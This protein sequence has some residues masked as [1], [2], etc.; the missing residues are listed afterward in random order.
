MTHEQLLG[1]METLTG[2]LHTSTTAEEQA[3]NNVQQ[4]LASSLAEQPLPVSN[5]QFSF[6][7]SDMFFPQNIQSGRLAN[8]EEIVS[9]TLDKK[10]EADLRVFARDLPVHTTQ[11][12]GSVPNWAAG[13]R[14][15]RTEGPFINND[16]RRIWFD[17]YRIERLVAIYIQGQSNPV[18]LF[19]SEF[20]QRLLD[21]FVNKNFRLIKSFKVLPG[22]VWVNAHALAPD[23]P[24]DRFTGVKVTGGSITLD[25]VPTL[26]GNNLTVDPTNKINV[27]LELDQETDAY[28]SVDSPY[29][30]DAR[31][32]TFHLP[33]TWNFTLVGTGK[34]ITT[35][36]E[37]SAT[38]YGQA[39]NFA[40]AGN[41]A[42]TY[43]AALSKVLIPW[44]AD[45]TEFDVSSSES[46]FFN[47]SGKAP[48]GGSW[49]A[50]PA[51][52]IDVSAP[53]EA[54]GNGAVLIACGK[55]L[56]AT[57]AGL[58][59]Q[60]MVFNQPF[61]MGEP[62]RIGLTDLFSNG[63]GAS[64]HLELWKDKKN[65]HGNSVD[66]LFLSSAAF[67][68]NSVTKGD[69][70]LI[71][72]CNAGLNIDRPVKVNG[73]PF[74]VKSKN[75][76]L[77]MAANASLRLLYLYDDNIIWDNTLPGENVPSQKLYS[78]AL[79]N[80]L[81]TV[82]A[83]NGCLL[84][85]TC[86]EGWKKITASNL[87]LTFGMYS[88]LPTLPDPYLV[89]LN[90][91]LQQFRNERYPAT[92]G[93]GKRTP[94]L[95]L[96]CNIQYKPLDETNDVVNVG[97]HFGLMPAQQQSNAQPSTHSGIQNTPGNS[98]VGRNLFSDI[99]I[100]KEKGAH[101]FASQKARET[102]EGIHA[103][104]PM[105]AVNNQLPDY[106]ALWD[107]RFGFLGSDAFALLDVSSNANQ[108]GVSFGGFSRRDQMAF[109][110][111]GNIVSAG[112][113]AAAVDSS[114]FPFIVDGMEVKASG[115]SVRAFM[116]P[117]VAWEP[118]F[119]LSA[120][121]RTDPLVPTSPK[122]PMDPEV[123]FKYFANDGGPTRILNNSDKPVTLAPIPLVDFLMDY[124]KNDPKSILASSLTLPFGLRAL[125]YITKNSQLLI[126]NNPIPA[127]QT[128]PPDLENT[129]PEFR[130]NLKGG[131]QITV[132]SGNF[133]KAVTDPTEIDSPML[134]GYTSQINNLLE[135]DGSAKGCSNLGQRVTD[136]FNNE[137]FTAPV[138][139]NDVNV[140]RG[141]PVTRLD[142]TGYGFN[143]LTNWLSPSAAMA[144]TSQARFDIMLGRTSHE[145]IQVK[146][147]IYPW[148]I[149]VVRT[150]TLI[151]ASTGYVFRYDSGWKAQSDG[152]FDFSYTYKDI[153]NNNITNNEP[154]TFHPGI[155]S[156]LYNVRNIK[157]APDL[158][159]FTSSNSIANG[160]VYLNGVIG[161]EISNAT[162]G[163][164]NEPVKC[165]AVYFD[166]DVEIENVK[167][168]HKDGRVVSKKV[169]GYVQL[170]PAGKP[171]SIQQF[172]ELL[173][174]QG[175]TIGADVDCGVDINNNNQQMRLSR[176]D[177]SP[178]I[179]E[180]NQTIFVVAARGNVVLPKDGSWSIVKHETGT[181]EVT[182]LPE[183]YPV[184][185][186]R[187][188]KW[189]KNKVI[190]PAV[191][192]GNL[193][194][195]AHPREIIRKVAA[196][197]INFGYLQNTTTQKVL[198]LT[199]SYG[200]FAPGPDIVPKLLSK[201][202]PIF[203]DAYRM[204]TGK[205]I[206]PNIGD[207]ITNFGK[208]M[209]MLNADGVQAFAENALK[210]GGKAVLELMEIKAEKVGEE[211]VQQ[212]LS[213]LK[214]GA[215]G[216]MNKALQFDVPDFNVYLVDMDALKIYIEYKATPKN[217]GTNPGKLDFDVE[218]FANKMEDQWKSRLNNLAMVVDL[219][220][221]K[222]IMTIKGNFNS[223]KGK[224]TGYEGDSNG[225]GG[226]PT[227]EI[228]F[229]DALKP[230]I[231]ILEMLAALSTGDYGEALK[232]GLKVAMSNAGEIWEYKFEAKKEIGLIRFPPTEQLYNSPQ[233][234]LKL[235]ASLSLGVYFDA[236]L[237]VTT[238]PKQLLPTA[239]AY[240]QFHG[241]LQVM[242]F[243]VGVGSIFAIG[244]V[245]VKIAAD[246]KVG[247]TLGLKFGFGA[248]IVVG[249]PVIANVSVTFLVGVEMNADIS[250]ISL[251]A[252][253][254]FRGHADIFGGIVS[255]T[256]TI[257]AKGIIV[258][259]I[260]EN[261]TDCSAQVTFALDISI[262][263]IINISFSKTWAEDR[264]VAAAD[265]KYG[266]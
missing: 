75:S 86:D 187:E 135:A 57:W 83:V 161:Q 117:Q 168:G 217:K 66:L 215:G 141:V 1:L 39:A 234:P 62:G 200:F 266:S 120:P 152:L 4:M 48:V 257:E 3:L 216:I 47:L 79:Q 9:K 7:G 20:R 203:A 245:D 147:L 162:G 212:G 176:V 165:G 182:P 254:Y 67:I 110:R 194:R 250:T 78:I 36:G 177:V 95:W 113:G 44:N 71:T 181:G 246:T 188:G 64:Q 72:L 101:L 123:G 160:Q 192:T 126:G 258:R 259:H 205:G 207:A 231:A 193:L 255:I 29:G 74:E 27:A 69:E 202:P 88:Y 201:T 116:E 136:V 43:N 265:S 40:W 104:Q 137:F 195:I 58:K 252:I 21:R 73:E 108:L 127:R 93:I 25:M 249:F 6:A 221:M 189:K 220:P 206:F 51:A 22:S 163:I 18:I 128:A 260:S 218:S 28:A 167:Q 87:F 97:F 16:G 99:F 103:T 138:A 143:M 129:Q 253:M 251:A 226:L 130:T 24:D 114:G 13:S 242:C 197:T 121:D 122:L 63:L 119:N 52:V 151:R 102:P 228:E 199:P 19:K 183:N 54:K 144:Q 98:L 156:G 37:A 198:F 133:S 227:P 131:I 111:T 263:F 244:S 186:I 89:N 50:L 229:S 210:D 17:F 140:S 81:F 166:A 236:A 261:R 185:L 230:V 190:D 34:N 68:F 112:E 142:F 214:K 146:S 96:I 239:G 53:L 191:V 222:K 223:N 157:D 240:L 154:Y 196:D 94:W 14:P 56:Q 225:D 132:F 164:L 171:L 92:G 155:I 208:A 60:D 82:S 219:G 209:P 65:P 115:R 26:Q 12:T 59:N 76:L 243:S 109:V 139:L 233:T 42:A 204:M 174:L 23:A 41:Q 11:V 150:I 106:Q 55:G 118:I 145:V 46:P 175:G 238:D 235:E 2:H 90:V 107:D 85:G 178:S 169:L 159:E 30:K 148:G 125:A 10:E 172:Q 248:Q 180:L 31:G 211:V 264:Q 45:I 149:R 32:A 77:A 173:S 224:E 213:L 35:I 70:L 33:G 256:I 61:L 38:M 124:F 170:A 262:A 134:P 105:M 184:P 179:D 84:F 91:L 49:W 15:V 153:A 158:A 241:G 100:S 5:Q 232:K 80:A 247:P 237:K 8:L